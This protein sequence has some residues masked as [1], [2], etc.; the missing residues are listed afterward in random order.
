VKFIKWL[1]FIVGLLLLI[2]LGFWAVGI[3]YSLLWYVFWLAIVGA[4]GYGGYR[5]LAGKEQRAELPENTPIAIAEIRTDRVL[6]EYKK[7]Y[8]NE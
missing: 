8:S 6:E 7:K 3:V 5:L 2:W 1:I 4:I